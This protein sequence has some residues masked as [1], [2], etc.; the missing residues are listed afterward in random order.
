MKALQLLCL[1]LV[2]SSLP[3]CYSTGKIYMD[4]NPTYADNEKPPH[5]TDADPQF[6]SGE[7]YF[8]I[9]K[10][11]HYVFSLLAKLLLWNWTYAD[12]D[13]TP[14]TKAYFKEYIK[15]N[16]LVGVKV[17]FNQYAPFAELGR[18]WDNERVHWGLKYTFGIVSWLYYT[19]I[20]ERLFA[21]L[22]GGDHFNPYTNTINVYSN[23]IPILLH[24]GGHAKD[25]EMR[26]SR[27]LYVAVRLIPIVGALYQEAVASDD[28]IV[29]LRDRCEKEREIR[30]YRELS[31]AYATYLFG[32]LLQGPVSLLAAIPGHG[33]G[34]YKANKEK[35]RPIEG[36]PAVGGKS[37]KVQPE[38][39][40]KP[41]E[42]NESKLEK[43][44]E[45]KIEPK[46]EPKTETKTP[47]EVKGK[48]AG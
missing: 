42:K 8:V 44:A 36:C 45:P 35:D 26:P 9:D 32:P 3:N 43:K 4:G 2:C 37:A 47:A 28:A 22:I 46:A 19:L 33:Y 6:E 21:G 41:A 27:N 38:S 7:P 20:P 1:L 30:A 39:V 34:I 16:N 48:S 15:R 13:I 10:L 25:F 18:L 23:S 29:Y 24:E 31:P 12:H 17:R 40:A 11:G 5:F 14:E